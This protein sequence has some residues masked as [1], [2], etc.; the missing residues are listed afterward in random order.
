MVSHR[1]IY[2]P[3]YY[4][5]SFFFYKINITTH[6]T[7]L[8]TI[9]TICDLHKK[10]KYF[11]FFLQQSEQTIQRT[12]TFLWCNMKLQIP[13]F[14]YYTSSVLVVS[15]PLIRFDLNLLFYIFRLGNNLY[16]G[17]ECLFLG[18]LRGHCHLLVVILSN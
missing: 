18:R 4:L 1:L 10:I 13:S 3:Y 15:W 7:S 12:C 16:K 11:C 17:E 5:V 6:F 2:L 14:F 8:Q 9:C